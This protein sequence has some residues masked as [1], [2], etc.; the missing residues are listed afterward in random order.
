MDLK[1]IPKLAT[2]GVVNQATTAVIGEAGKEAVMPLERNTGWIAQLSQQIMSR[3]N[4][5]SISLP[6]VNNQIPIS[7][8][9]SMSPS[10]SGKTIS[11]VITIAKLADSIVVKEKEDIEEISEKV[12]EKILEVVENM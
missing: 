1:H 12:A 3:M 5:M 7:N 4:G 6:V 11:V 9:N 10:S 8:G 2:G